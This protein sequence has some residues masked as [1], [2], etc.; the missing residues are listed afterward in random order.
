MLLSS[1]LSDSLSVNCPCASIAMHEII[2][3]D[4]EGGNLELPLES[5]GEY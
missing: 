5:N 4:V 1:K 3:I 2:L